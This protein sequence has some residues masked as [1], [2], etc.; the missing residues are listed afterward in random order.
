VTSAIS[1]RE[2]PEVWRPIAVP[3][4][5][6]GSSPTFS[7]VVPTRGRETLA[8]TLASISSQLEPGDEIIVVCTSDEDWGNSARQR[9]IEKATSSHVLFCDDDDVFLPGAL[10]VMRQFAGEHPGAVGIFRRRFNAG[11]PQ[12]R[13]PVLRPTNVQCM[14]FVIPN[15]PGKLGVW[16][17]QSSDPVKQAALQA[18]G[19]R[20][21]SDAYFVSETAELQGARVI[22]CDVI[23]GHARPEPNPF[24]RLRYRLKLRTR[25]RRSLRR[26]A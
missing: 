21:W 9:G 24:R 20:P 4:R 1:D 11:P 3:R 6:A 25:L 14:G 7:V 10:A 2:A 22:F 23:V 5:P 17:P 15:V 12:W 8:R 26:G 18:S 16:G 19:V 13:E